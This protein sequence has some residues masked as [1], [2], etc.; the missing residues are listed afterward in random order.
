MLH[1]VSDSLIARERRFAS[2]DLSRWFLASRVSRN[3]STLLGAGPKR[4]E[5]IQS[6]G[7][8]RPVVLLDWQVCCLGLSRVQ[9]L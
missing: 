3:T 8:A 4:I 6:G 1:S 9:S 7:K 2:S 5:M